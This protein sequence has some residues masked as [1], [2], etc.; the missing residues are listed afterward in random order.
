MQREEFS[1]VANRDVGPYIL[2]NCTLRGWNER[3]GGL[4]TRHFGWSFDGVA[5]YVASGKVDDQ[6]GI[7]CGEHKVFLA[8]HMPATTTGTTT[9]SRQVRYTSA[10]EAS[11]ANEQ[12]AP[13]LPL[14]LPIN[15]AICYNAGMV[16]AL[17]VVESEV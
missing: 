6:R 2:C 14:P 7:E 17:R 1:V 11:L 16:T 5:V 10:V 13:S 9:S 15:G 4:W 3:Q 12:R 8:A